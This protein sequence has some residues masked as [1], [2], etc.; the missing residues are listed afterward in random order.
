MKDVFRFLAVGALS[1][2]ATAMTASAITF[3]EDAGS[4]DPPTPTTPGAV[5]EDNGET[6]GFLVWDR[7]GRTVAGAEDTTGVG[8]AG[9]TGTITDI[10]PSL[11]TNDADLWKINIT[12]PANFFA[13][14]DGG[15]LLALFDASGTALSAVQS[16]GGAEVL[17][18]AGLSGA[19]IY[20]LGL[21]ADGNMPQ[22]AAGDPLFVM[23]GNNEV[24]ATVQADMTLATDPFVAWSDFN[25]ECG[26]GCDPQNFTPSLVGP[27]NF[28]RGSSN[29][30]L[31]EPASA[32]LIALGGLALLRRRR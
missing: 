21:G 8:D 3:N 27:G 30:G 16:T 18:N 2:G 25:N 31:P 4:G 15:H 13:V 26:F 10:S 28:T 7:W 14:V 23:N 5:L 9:P 24:A 22:N 17:S 12:D 1:L 11:W 20:Y 29:V 19:G 32:S 6:G